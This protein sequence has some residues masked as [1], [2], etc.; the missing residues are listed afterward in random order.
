MTLDNTARMKEMEEFGSGISRYVWRGSGRVEVFSE[1]GGQIGDKKRR[2]NGVM[3]QRE[4][5]REP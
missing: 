1:N 4:M 3:T 2:E 5:R